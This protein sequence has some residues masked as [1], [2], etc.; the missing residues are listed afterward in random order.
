MRSIFRRKNRRSAET[1]RQ[2]RE[3]KKGV[4]PSR[5]SPLDSPVFRIGLYEPALDMQ[6]NHFL[7]RYDAP[8]LFHAGYRRAFG[9][10]KG[11]RS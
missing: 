1:N 5:L 10:R 2:E 4:R 6:F 3:R 9:K 8:L 7:V 11:V